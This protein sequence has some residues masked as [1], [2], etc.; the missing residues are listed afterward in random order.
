MTPLNFKPACAIY[1]HID[2]NIERS[3]ENFSIIEYIPMRY[4]VSVALHGEHILTLSR[5]RMD[6]Q[7]F[8]LFRIPNLQPIVEMDMNSD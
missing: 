3:Y 1:E 4:I 5:H 8:P 6:G 7:F 2:H